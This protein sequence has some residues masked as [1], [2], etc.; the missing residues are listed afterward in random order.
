ML[1]LGTLSALLGL[2]LLAGAGAAG[3]ANYQQRDGGYFT[4]PLERFSADSYALSSPRLDVM[5]GGGMPDAGPVDLAGSVLLRG[6]AGVRILLILVAAILG[7]LAGQALGARL[8]DPVRLGDFSL[9][10]ASVLAWVG[11]GIVAVATTLG[12]S[13]QRG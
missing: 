10:W 1:V 9:I 3:W 6:S 8:G 13:R 12:P 11:I 5:T 4:S 7:A 2:G